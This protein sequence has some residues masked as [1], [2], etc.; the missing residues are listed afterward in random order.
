MGISKRGEERSES[1]YKVKSMRFR[2]KNPEMSPR[3]CMKVIP[4][5]F[6]CSIILSIV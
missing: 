1:D 3:S 6:H 2:E 5:P 4:L